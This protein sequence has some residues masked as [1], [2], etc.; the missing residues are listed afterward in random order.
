VQDALEASLETS[1]RDSANLVLSFCSDESNIFNLT[2]I[3]KHLA[4]AFQCGNKILICGNGGSACDAMHFAEEFTGRYRKDRRALPV[5]HLA[6]PGHLTCVGND[7][8]FDE[9]FARSVEAFGKKDDWLIGLSTSGNSSNVV[10]AFEKAKALELKTLSLLGK[11]GGKLKGMCDHEII[12]P[13]LTADRIQEVHMTILHVIIEGVERLLF[14][15][16]YE[17]PP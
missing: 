10:R 5:I 16:N 11:N 15:K 6:D 8:G 17:V 4:N 3:A 7:Y 9:I 2:T 14:P 12:I 13:G 1:L